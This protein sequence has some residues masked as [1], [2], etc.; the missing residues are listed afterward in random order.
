MI[1]LRIM[2]ALLGSSLMFGEL[3]RSWGQDRNILFVVDDF[4]IGLFLIVMAILTRKTSTLK[5]SGLTGAFALSAGVLYGSF[6]GKLVNP[7]QAM[8]S[9]L[10]N[11]ILTTLVGIAFVLSLIGLVSSLY[12][13]GKHESG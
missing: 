9:N 2:A 10:D 13:S 11:E 5:L 7:S 1:C 4:L 12:F 3:L 8:S 6:F